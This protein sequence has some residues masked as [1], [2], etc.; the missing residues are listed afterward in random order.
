MRNFKP[1]PGG[2]FLEYF[3]FALL[4]AFFVSKVV[5]YFRYDLLLKCTTCSFR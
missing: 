1:I 4:F 5:R 3:V 2:I